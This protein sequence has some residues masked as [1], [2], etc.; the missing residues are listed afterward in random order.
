MAQLVANTVTEAFLDWLDTGDPSRDDEMVDLTD[1]G[2][3]G[4]VVV[5]G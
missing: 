3:A 2:H 5:G 1:S 4:W